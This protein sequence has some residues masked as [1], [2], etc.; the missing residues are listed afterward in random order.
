MHTNAQYPAAS[1]PRGNV[2][3]LAAASLIILAGITACKDPAPT[4]AAEAAG[5]TTTMSMDHGPAASGFSVQVLSRTSFIDDIDAT[6]R[7][8]QGST[9]VIH[10]NDPSDVVV[11]KVT[12]QPGG[13]LGWHT[14]PGP[15]IATVAAGQLTIIN[16]KDCVTRQYPAGKAFIDPGQGNVHVG[17]NT[18][19]VET[20]VYVTFLDVPAG[21]SPTIPSPEPETC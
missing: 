13:S 6:F 18:T 17:F 19:D 4:S 1:S 5:A 2:R 14:H 8:K 7:L 9:N 11:A 3:K 15:A 10:V 12:V 20:V 21:Q 16:A